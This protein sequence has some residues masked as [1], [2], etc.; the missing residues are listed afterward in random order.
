MSGKSVALENWAGSL[1]YQGV[2]VARPTSTAELQEI[3]A[4]SDNV[5]ALG[6]RHS[7][8][9]VADTTGTLVSVA[10][11]PAVLEV[12]REQRCATVSAGM[13]YGA[14][15]AQLD[16]AGWARTG[17]HATFGQ[18]DAEGLLRLAVDHDEEHLG[19]LR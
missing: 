6:S 13:L 12:D 4:G 7:F 14:L 11:L 17:R 16:E 19:G 5:K 15:A 18:L 8:S 10:G 1:R 2:E 9:E 3:V